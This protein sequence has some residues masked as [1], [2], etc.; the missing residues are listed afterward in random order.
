MSRRWKTGHTKTKKKVVLVFDD[1]DR[2]Q[3]NWTELLGTIN[4]YCENQH[5]NSIIVATTGYF[6]ET[7]SDSLTLIN[8]AK[9]KTIAY[10]VLNCPVYG[11]IVHNV[12]ADTDWKTKEYGEFLKEHEQT[13]LE[14]FGSD[15]QDETS[16]DAQLSK[17]HNIRSLIVALESFY[18]VY[19]H[20]TKAEI[21]DIEPY[22]CSFIAFYLVTKSGATKNG[23]NCF[24]LTDAEISQLYPRFSSD[25]LLDSVSHWILRG[26]WD[27]DQFQQELSRIGIV[28]APGKRD[29]EANEPG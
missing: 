10:H 7:K 20:M 1:T 27:K 14:L 18:R 13:I 24:E 3:L 5:F 21:K 19:Y 2:S 26:Y 15:P 9:E 8:T 17:H 16:E 4:D 29:D 11:N 28:N 6:N 22:F 23:K 25:T 12:I